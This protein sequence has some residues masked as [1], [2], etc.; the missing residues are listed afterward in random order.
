MDNNALLKIKERLNNTIKVLEEQTAALKGDLN[1]VNQ[2]LEG[3]KDTLNKVGENLKKELVDTRSK[4]EENKEKLENLSEN[5]LKSTSIDYFSELEK[6]T[7]AML[8]RMKDKVKSNEVL[9][10]LYE[11]VQKNTKEPITSEQNEPEDELKKIQDERDLEKKVE[12]FKKMD[13]LN[14]LKNKLKGNKKDQ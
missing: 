13:A 6:E 2:I 11:T 12:G 5:D 8:H 1:Q 3:G 7:I 9:A 10:D 14:D 4:I